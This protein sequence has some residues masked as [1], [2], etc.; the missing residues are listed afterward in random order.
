MFAKIPLLLVLGVAAATSIPLVT[1]DGN[2]ATTHSFKELNDPVMGGQSNGTW[3]V[4]TGFGIFDGNVNIVRH[5]S[6][7]PASP[8]RPFPSRC[9]FPRRV[10]VRH[11]SEA[12]AVAVWPLASSAP[13]RPH[14]TSIFAHS[15]LSL[16]YLLSP[17]PAIPRSLRSPPH[18]PHT[19]VPSLKAPGFIKASAGGGNFNDASS[20]LTGDLVLLVRSNTP[21]YAGFRVTVAAGALSPA[22]SCAAGGAIIGSGGCYKA[23]FTVP[24]G[25]NFTEVRIPFN[26][27]SDKWSSATGEPTKTCAADKSVCPTAK[28]LSKI[29]TIEIWGEGKLGHV[30]LEVKSISASA[31]AAAAAPLTEASAGA[32]VLVTFDGTVGTTHAFKTLNDPVM[33]GQSNG[34]FKVAGGLGIFDGFVNIVPKLK[35]P[36]F[37]ET[38]AN[39]GH[40][41]DA[42]SAGA[43]G[44]LVLRVR[45]NTPTY[46]GFR[47]TFASGA[48]STSFSCAAGGSI[49]GSGGCYK[50][51]FTVP[52]SGSNF[53]EVRVPLN[54]FTDKWSSSTGKPTKTCAADKSVC[55][56]AAKLAKIQAVGIWGE[57][58]QGHL[59]LE[60]ASIRAE[61]ASMRPKTLAEAAVEVEAAPFR[62]AAQYD[63]CNAAVQT[64][65]RYNISTLTSAD[66][67]VP[68]AVDPRESLAT[69]IC[70]D[71]RTQVF[72]EPRFL[73]QSPFVD[74]FKHMNQDGPT[75]FY[76]SVCGIPLFKAPMNRS[77]ADFQA[78]TTEHGWPS[79]RP[80]EIIDKDSF[81]TTKDGFVYSKC[82]THLGSFLPDDKGDRWCLDTSCLAGNPAK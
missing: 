51:A 22:F 70:C 2:K 7:S 16:S 29:Q 59:H 6:A 63:T 23:H 61:P 81:H 69:A 26:T 38:W 68:V 11:R 9:R 31:P 17:S 64:N 62:P 42:S 77:F 54:T 13:S 75:I 50:A 74:L 27:F 37:I 43:D 80:A 34:T 76:D 12:L 14:H 5:A 33:G 25:G 4:G 15:P 67:T 60:I 44:D 28:A 71:N 66:I 57:G 39:D 48:L 79:F 19:Q 3:T 18:S 72:A 32:S 35:A 82:G 10:R 58:V 40:F 49:I 30:H 24:A 36:G 21:T 1:F 41:T 47:V 55:P 20:A 73:F 45:S 52:A 65:L 56:T 46:A 53:T 78:D 8:P